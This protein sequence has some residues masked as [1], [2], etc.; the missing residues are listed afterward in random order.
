MKVLAPQPWLREATS[1]CQE[2]EGKGELRT[3]EESLE[4]IQ[5]QEKIAAE[6]QRVKGPIRSSE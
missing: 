2:L 6:M 3:P 5:L 1:R 4:F